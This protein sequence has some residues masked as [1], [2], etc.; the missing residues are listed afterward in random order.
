MSLAFRIEVVPQELLPAIPQ[1]ALGAR[2]SSVAG[3]IGGLL[4]LELGQGMGLSV[5]PDTIPVM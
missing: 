2:S 4:R 1:S 3:A 5:C